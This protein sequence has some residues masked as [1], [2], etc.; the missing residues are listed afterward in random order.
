MD[1][2]GAGLD[3]KAEM[4]F[5]THEMDRCGMTKMRERLF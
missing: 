3:G 2:I 5:E 4:V 1:R